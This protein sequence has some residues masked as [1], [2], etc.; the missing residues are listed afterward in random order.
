VPII[1]LRSINP[2]RIY[3]GPVLSA[4]KFKNNITEA[5]ILNGKFKGK[6]VLLPRILMIPTDMF[7]DIKR[8]QFSM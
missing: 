6:Y 8:L 4:K 3:N 1:F 2:P 7:F 5:T